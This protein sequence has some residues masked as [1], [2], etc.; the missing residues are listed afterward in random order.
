MW[1]VI[2]PTDRDNRS[3]KYICTRTFSRVRLFSI[4]WTVACQS[5]LFM[6]FSRQE[7]WSGLPFP[8]PGD[9]PNPGIKLAFPGSCIAGRFFITEPPGKRPYSSQSHCLWQRLMYIPLNL[10]SLIFQGTIDRLHFPVCF[11]VR[12]SCWVSSSQQQEWSIGILCFIVL[13]RS[14]FFFFNKR[15]VYGN[16]ALSDSV[17]IF[18]NK[19]FLIK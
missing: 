12:Y 1:Q 9:V 10:Y 18:I 15:M 7:H 6:E 5:S 8:S 13:C 19:V 16:P 2:I 11:A 14:F 4:P 3:S 17:N